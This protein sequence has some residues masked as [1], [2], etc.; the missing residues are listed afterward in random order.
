MAAARFRKLSRP[1]ADG[2]LTTLLQRHEGAGWRCD[3][4]LLAIG[5]LTMPKTV[6]SPRQRTYHRAVHLAQSPVHSSGRVCLR[7]IVTT[8]E[9]AALTEHE[10]R[11]LS[12]E[13][14]THGDLLPLP[15]VPHGALR[16][17]IDAA[18][19][20]L[21]A[22]CVLKILSWLQYAAAH[23]RA[24]FV[25]Y[26]DDDTF[27]GL[28]RTMQTL[29]VLRQAMLQPGNASSLLLYGGAM[30]Y[31][32]F[33]DFQKMVAHGYYW[34]FPTAGRQF[35]KEYAE[36]AA[37]PFNADASARERAA[38]FHRPFPMAHGHAVITSVALA[39]EL[40]RAATV[41]DFVRATHTDN[42]SRA[43]SQACRYCSKALS[44]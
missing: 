7:Y 25:A 4:E 22:N 2:E 30:Q 16:Q 5:V 8:A 28:S 26:G 34:T 37:M 44:L 31:H 6:R 29:V 9:L 13:N 36:G 10:A 39:A 43:G 19:A 21:G 18:D 11:N 35:L 1:R 23:L 41:V 42:A 20:P 3:P 17:A 40:P 12:A 14:S 32:A 33:W 38:P 27:W 15:A 24:P